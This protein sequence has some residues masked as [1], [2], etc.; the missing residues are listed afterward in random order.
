[1]KMKSALMIL[2][3]LLNDVEG[4]AYPEKRYIELP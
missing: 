4:R 1:M 3:N 2:S